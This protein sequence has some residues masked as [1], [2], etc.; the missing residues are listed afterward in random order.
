[1]SEWH[2]TTW[3]RISELLY[4]KALRKGDYTGGSVQVFG[5][6]GPIG[7]HD[8]ELF[9]PGVVVGRKGAYRGIH[10]ASGPCW[11]I[12]TAFYL[13]VDHQRVT[14]RWAYYALK[15]V[16]LNSIDS[17]SAIP[18]TTR[19]A[20]ASIPVRLPPIDLQQRVC[21]ILDSIDDLIENN[22][23]RIEVLEEMAQAIYREWFVHF[24]YPGHE[25]ASFVDSPLGPIPE[26]WEVELVAGAVERLQP[27]RTYKAEEVA[28]T[29]TVVVI[30]QS[31]DELLGFHS[32]EPAHRASP[33]DPV[34]VFGDHTCK[35]RIVIEP[36]SVGPNVVPFK[37]SAGRALSYVVRALDGAVSTTEYKRHWTTLMAKEIAL[38]PATI[39]NAFD[40]R[41]RPL[42]EMSE[43]LRRESRAVSRVR[44]FL[45]PKLVTGEINL[46][47]LDLDD[48]V[49]AVS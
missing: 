24:R 42:T 5:T 7:W 22:R 4:G 12:D 26:G 36:F 14:D 16:D 9:P 1:V 20:F 29:G 43:T 6:N 25:D 13:N 49:E 37:S 15:I 3:G 32:N 28:E 19:P 38:A 10:Y 45:L 44:D 31:R 35:L 47:A 34:A 48:L 33:H 17:G 30:D 39:S 40:H 11:V 27:G 2:E 46:S 41:I 18:S 8:L 21:G 23:R